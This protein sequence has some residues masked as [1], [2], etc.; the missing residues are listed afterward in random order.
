MRREPIRGDATFCICYQLIGLVSSLVGLCVGRHGYAVQERLNFI[1]PVVGAENCVLVGRPDRGREG[2]LMT[3]GDVAFCQTTLDTCY[4]CQREFRCVCC[5]G[6]GG[7]YCSQ[8]ASD[9]T[10]TSSSSTGDVITVSP[11]ESKATARLNGNSGTTF[12]CHTADV[13]IHQRDLHGHSK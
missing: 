10:M 1:A 3:G 2:A 6:Y 8:V 13:A 5:P 9:V 11:A 7:P 12:I 4:C